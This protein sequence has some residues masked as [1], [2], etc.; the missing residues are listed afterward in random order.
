MQLLFSSLELFQCK[1]R[2]EHLA[3]QSNVPFCASAKICAI[4]R[5]NGLGGH[6]QLLEPGLAA[7]Q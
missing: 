1:N 5:R 7:L 3:C 2:H 4:F 6:T